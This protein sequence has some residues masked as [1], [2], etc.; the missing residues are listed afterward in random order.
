MCNYVYMCLMYMC[1][2]EFVFVPICS[3]LCQFESVTYVCLFP[4]AGEIHLCIS[5]V[6]CM[7]S[8]VY[9]DTFQEV[10][11]MACSPDLNVRFLN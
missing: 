9:K 8:H 7:F 5:F 2:S 10:S 1:M 4:L 11:S 3:W 6:C